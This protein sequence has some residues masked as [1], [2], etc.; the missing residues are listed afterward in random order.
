MA[1]CEGAFS[2]SRLITLV[3]ALVLCAPVVAGAGTRCAV[4]REQLTECSNVEDLVPSGMN[5]SYYAVPVH[6]AVNLTSWEEHFVTKFKFR[7]EAL[8][9]SYDCDHPY[10]IG[11]CDDCRREY[12]RWLCREIAICTELGGKKEECDGFHECS[13]VN[14][15][16]SRV[17]A[18]KVEDKIWQW[19][20]KRCQE[21]ARTCPYVVKFKC[22]S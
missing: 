1:S 2:L 19:G 6:V 7:L 11:T 22:P 12:R 5:T 20:I 10:G 4:P 8:F 3:L 21:V 14:I 15:G 13:T 18:P 16:D 9:R 17:S